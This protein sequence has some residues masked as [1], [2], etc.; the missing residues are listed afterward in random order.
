MYRKAIIDSYNEKVKR[1]YGPNSAYRRPISPGP[2]PA[3]RMRQR[4]PSPPARRSWGE[5][6]RA[7]LAW[8][9]VR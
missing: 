5:L 3:S 1:L 4:S 9:G 7:L 6:R 2:V 8:P